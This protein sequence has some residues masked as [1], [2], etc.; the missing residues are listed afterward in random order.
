M[1]TKQIALPKYLF[2]KDINIDKHSIPC[3]VFSRS[4]P[5]KSGHLVCLTSPN[6]EMVFSYLRKFLLFEIKT[7]CVMAW[8]NCTHTFC[9]KKLTTIYML[10]VLFSSQHKQCHE[11]KGFIN[12]DPI[13]IP[14]MWYFMSRHLIQME[15]FN[16][17]IDEKWT[18]IKVY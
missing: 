4:M 9:H 12:F 3:S 18:W 11:Y 10:A 7:N 8:L 6:R 5:D 2:Y 14:Y 13:S 15:C 1:R 16:H 17:I